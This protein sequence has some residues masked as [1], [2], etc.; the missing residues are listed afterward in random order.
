MTG[1]YILRRC[2]TLGALAVAACRFDPSGLPNGSNADARTNDA[3]VADAMIGPDTPPGTPDADTTDAPPV[4]EWPQPPLHFD[5]CDLPAGTA[6]NLAILGRYLYHTDSGVLTDP[7]NN[8]SV[9]PS[10]LVDQGDV[11]V[12][13]L[14]VSQFS[15]GVTSTLRVVGTR[16]LIIASETNIVINGNLN[17]SSLI[18]PLGLEL[19]TGAGANPSICSLTGAT[20]GTPAAGTAANQGGSGGGGGALRGDGGD[21]GDGNGVAKGTGGTAVGLPLELR[22]GCPGLEGGSGDGATGGV[23]GDGGGAI[24]LA[25]RNSITISGL[26]QAGGQRGTRGLQGA[27]GGGAGAGGAGSGGMIYI[28]TNMFTMGPAATLAANGGGGGEGG[29]DNQDGATN[30]EDGQ[31]SASAASKGSG[32]ANNGG[33]GGDGSAGNTLDGHDAQTKDSG[34][35]GGGGAGYIIFRSPS[36]T[37]PGGVTISPAEQSQ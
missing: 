20:A 17:A 3:T 13:V 14:A 27:A 37:K 1:A 22:G 9:P 36:I 21:G 30:A 5:P 7:A 11:E 26:V 15:L 18:D 23:G 4:C 12:R 34:G 29:D 6:L 2:A 24:E 8:T 25:A 19:P 16:P 32:A 33:D 28:D 35:G 31:P 10:L